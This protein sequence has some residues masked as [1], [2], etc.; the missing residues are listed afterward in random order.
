M[1]LC[2]NREIMIKN[3][4]LKKVIKIN[5]K[6]NIESVVCSYHRRLMIANWRFV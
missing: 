5:R 6:K 4:L 3:T 1:E 2:G